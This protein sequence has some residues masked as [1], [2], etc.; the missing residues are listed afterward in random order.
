MRHRFWHGNPHGKIRNQ[1]STC[2]ICSKMKKNSP[3]GGQLAPRNIPNIP[4]LE[5]HIDLI[6]PWELKSQNDAA[7]F[8][9]MI[10]A[11]PVTD[12]VEMARVTSTK[13]AKNARTF[14]NAWSSW[15][16]KPDKVVTDNGLEIN[17]NK[18][19]FMLM[20]WGIRKGMISSHT[21]TADAFVE[22]SHHIIGQILRTMSH[23][24]AVR[25]KVELEAALD[26]ACAIATRVMHCVSDISSQGNAPGAVVFGRDM[27]VNVPILMDI[28]AIS[29][30]QQL[31]TDTKLMHE[32]QCC[33]LHECAVGQQVCVN[34]HFSSVDELKH[35]WV[36]PFPILRVHVNGTFTIQ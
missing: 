10:I 31:Q 18:W 30:D 27:N 36:G 4:W 2:D 26:N 1:L 17:G 11:D 8:W 16:P 22:S 5:A 35:V 20:D 29:A 28:V 24:A 7:K 14:K 23:G 13:S 34:N 15:C 25:T 3:K 12:L 19:E 9:A 32:N 21:P 6:G 33:V